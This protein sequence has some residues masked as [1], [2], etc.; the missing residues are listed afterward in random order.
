M[1]GGFGSLLAV[2]L[3]RDYAGTARFV[4]RLQ[5]FTQAVSLGGVESLA[6]HAA[7]MWA[8]TMNDEQMRQ[9]GVLPQAVRL[10]VGLE[11][12]NDLCADLAQA[13]DEPAGAA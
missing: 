5:L 8:G 12:A 10:S 7:A 6:V 1:T 11:S 3:R 9:A 13:L 2:W 4:N